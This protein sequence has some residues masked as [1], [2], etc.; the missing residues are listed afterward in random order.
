MAPGAG[1][2]RSGA[3]NARTGESPELPPASATTVH[4]FDRPFAVTFF[5]N[6]A[7]AHKHEE[8]FTLRSLADRVSTVTASAKARLPWLKLARFGEM[9]SDKHSLR[10]DA[11]V[12]A[13]SGIEGD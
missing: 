12:G 1:A 4:A 10:H 5:S 9:K 2:A 11:N 8:R 13:I 3:M 6:A 7:A